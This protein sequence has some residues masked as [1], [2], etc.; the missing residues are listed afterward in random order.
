MPEKNL[1]KDSRILIIVGPTSSGKSELAVRL[2]KK[3]NGEI[4]S[5]DSRQIYRGMDLGTGKIRGQ[6]NRKKSR[7]DLSDRSNRVYVYKSIAHHLIDFTSP[8]ARFSVARFKI[9]AQKTIQDILHQGKL[10][11]LCGGTGHWIDAVVFDLPIPNVK[12]NWKLRQQ[13]EKQSA[14]ALYNRL[15]KLDPQRAATIDRRN[16]R[17]LIRALEIIITTGKPIPPLSPKPSTLYPKVLWLGI[18]LPQK[19]LYKKID[20]RLD[21]RIKAGLIK[22]VARLHSPPKIG[23]VAASSGRGGISWKRLESCGLEYRFVTRY[24]QNKLTYDEMIRQLSFAIKHFAKRQMTWWK[25]NKNIHWI[26]DYPAAIR[27][28]K[29]P[30]RRPGLLTGRRSRSQASEAAESTEALHPPS[31]KLRRM[32]RSLFPRPGGRGLRRWVKKGQP[33]G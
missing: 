7:R 17:R 4:V 29:L 31:L 25:R 30:G 6:W 13:L 32:T 19:L 9:L 15:Y 23:G 16:K 1:R 10:P 11:I 8:R 3:F 12:P 27:L 18:N 22:E 28:V 5:C 20:A 26:K 24:L 33:Y 14:D 2:A 21:Q